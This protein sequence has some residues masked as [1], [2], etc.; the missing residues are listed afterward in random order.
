MET[1]HNKASEWL[2]FIA[3][4]L[5][6]VTYTALSIVAGTG[7]GSVTSIVSL[8]A[9]AVTGIAATVIL[10]LY[11]KTNR[12][13]D[14]ES[15]RINA[16]SSRYSLFLMIVSVIP[17]IL[18]LLG[19]A[20]IPDFY[21]LA[22]EQPSRV[23]FA[24]TIITIYMTAFPLLALS[25]RKVPRLVIRP[26]KMGIGVFIS[27]LCMMAGLALIGTLIGAPIHLILTA[28]FASEDTTDLAKIILSSTLIERILVTAVLAPVFEELIFR[29]LLIDRTIKYGQT[30]SIF[31]SGLLFGLFHGN[32]Q[33]FFFATLIGM[34][35]ALV[36][37]RTGRIRYS[38][39][40]HAA[41][42]FSTSF[43]TA[44]L[45]IKVYPYLESDFKSVPTEII[46]ALGVLAIWMMILLLVAVIGIVLMIVWR[47]R[48]M[49]YRA[50]EEPSAGAVLAGLMKSPMFW[51]CTAIALSHF[52]SA[53]LPDIV[54]TLIG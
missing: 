12:G 7:S 44:S 23:S 4:I 26:H 16:V 46:Y 40:L 8:A 45:L 53:Y 11:F 37:I 28:P 36:Y 14:P 48:L 50:P 41:M 49:P 3:S 15:P 52:A 13:H 51:S 25:L 47:R 33:Q 32:F 1:S 30:L 9:L 17:L 18:E 31:L 5:F 22:D 2:A 43:V 10:I 54:N 39:L 35:F 20:I 6:S 27:C 24:I 34:L 42:N 38:I 29:K 21:Q 19:Y